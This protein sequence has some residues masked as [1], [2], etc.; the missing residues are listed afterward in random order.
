MFLIRLSYL[1]ALP[2]V[3][4]FGARYREGQG[5]LPYMLVIFCR[6]AMVVPLVLFGLIE[7]FG[8][9]H[10]LRPLEVEAV[11][12]V[13]VGSPALV[14]CFACLINGKPMAL[15]YLPEY[16]LVRILRAYFT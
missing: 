6:R 2:N 13:S 12:A 8:G 9:F 7:Y 1:F 10:T 16:L 14:A 3:D 5:R 15:L 11:I 4:F